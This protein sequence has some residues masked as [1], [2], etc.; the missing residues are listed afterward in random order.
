MKVN[1]V[2]QFKEFGHTGDFIK[3]VVIDVHEDLVFEDTLTIEKFDTKES[4][5]DKQIW[6]MAKSFCQEL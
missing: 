1:S 5:G 2:V 3:G 4:K 6:E